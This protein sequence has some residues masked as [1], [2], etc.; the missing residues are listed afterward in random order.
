MANKP[1]G[2]AQPFKLT[3]QQE[4]A[5]VFRIHQIGKS[6]TKQAAREVA[7]QL[8]SD[9]ALKHLTFDKRNQKAYTDTIFA[10]AE[11]IQYLFESKDREEFE[12]RLKE[13]WKW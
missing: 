5:T 12:K 13:R 11:A 4:L 3:I 2:K 6:L 1:N 8:A 9:H 10:M 7:M